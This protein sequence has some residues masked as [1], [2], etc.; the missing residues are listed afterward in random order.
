M[1]PPA[2]NEG[3]GEKGGAEDDCPEAELAAGVG[4]MLAGDEAVG[5]FPDE[6]GDEGEDDDSDGEGNGA[7]AAAGLFLIFEDAQGTED[8]AAGAVGD[9]VVAGSVFAGKG[10]EE[11]GGGGIYGARGVFGAG[12]QW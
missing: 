12:S 5:G 1:F 7:G 2:G 6:W 11:V 3:G 4:E 9:G 10:G 8:D